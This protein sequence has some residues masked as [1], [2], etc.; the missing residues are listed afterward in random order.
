MSASVSDRVETY[1][2]A[3]NDRDPA[4]V[5]AA[6]VPGGTYSDPNVIGPPLER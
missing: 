1:F 3:W 4:G 5:V 2:A 6:L